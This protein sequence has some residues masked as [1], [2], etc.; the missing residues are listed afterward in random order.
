MN[1]RETL[2]EEE[3][4]GQQV[5]GEGERAKPNIPSGKLRD[6]S[7]TEISNRECNFLLPCAVTSPSP[8]AQPPFA[9]VD[10]GQAS[11]WMSGGSGKELELQAGSARAVSLSLLPHSKMPLKPGGQ[12]RTLM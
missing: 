1:S 6:I 7:T 5:R 3:D 12:F 8:R 4:R 2:S 9:E 11:A 10:G